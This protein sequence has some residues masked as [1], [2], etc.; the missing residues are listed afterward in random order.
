MY[1]QIHQLKYTVKGFPRYI[2]YKPVHVDMGVQ[3]LD[4]YDKSKLQDI[5]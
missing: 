5:G 4:I 2:R 3:D 1:L